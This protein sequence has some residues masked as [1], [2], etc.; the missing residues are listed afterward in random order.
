MDFDAVMKK[1]DDLLIKTFK[2][3]KNVTLWPGGSSPRLIEAIFDQPYE[4]TDI[5]DG[6]RIEGSS[7]SITARDSDIIDL[8][9]KDTVYV[10]EDKFFVKELQPD[11]LGMTRVML[12]EYKKSAFDI[13]DSR[14]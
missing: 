3:I 14:L 1:A 13:P 12:S 7:I 11:G 8:S 2:T 4:R 9:R 5:P 10:G 6:G